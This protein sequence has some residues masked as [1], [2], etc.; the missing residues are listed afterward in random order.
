MVQEPQKGQ[1]VLLISRLLMPGSGASLADIL[2][3]RSLRDLIQEAQYI[4]TPSAFLG[5]FPTELA[6]MP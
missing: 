1:R 4:D 3:V 6:A 2:R 5:R